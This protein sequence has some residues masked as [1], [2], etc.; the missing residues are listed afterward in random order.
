MENNG[1]FTTAQWSELQQQVQPLIDAW[2][3]SQRT[4]FPAP[5]GNNY[6]TA[7]IHFLM[8]HGAI[9]EFKPAERSKMDMSGWKGR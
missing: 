6:N 8:S 1:I 7:N 9:D 3:F 5:S 4:T 2:N